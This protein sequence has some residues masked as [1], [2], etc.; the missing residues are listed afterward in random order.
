MLPEHVPEQDAAVGWLP[1]RPRRTA[2]LVALDGPSFST[3]VKCPTCRCSGIKS[4][5]RWS[6]WRPPCRGASYTVTCA[7]R[8]F[9]TTSS[10]AFASCSTRGSFR[11]GR[12]LRRSRY[13][14]AKLISFRLS[15]YDFIV[16]D[17]FDVSLEGY[18]LD[19]NIHFRPQHSADLGAVRESVFQPVRAA[20]HS[21]YHRPAVRQHAGPALRH[22]QAATGDVHA[23]AVVR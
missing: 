22:A 18:R 20:R 8:T 14:V 4:R 23:R 7:C 6:V 10:R 17:L 19:L 16:N 1:G 5:W 2:R 21:P 11:L 15:A 9:C 3:A 13:D 12:H